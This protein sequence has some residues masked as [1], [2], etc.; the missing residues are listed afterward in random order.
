MKS[1][2]FKPSLL[3]LVILL[4]I[5]TANYAQVTPPEPPEPPEPIHLQE[6]PSFDSKDLQLNMKHLQVKMKDLQKQIKLKMQKVQYQTKLNMKNFDKQFKYR[7]KNM[8]Y[9][10]DSLKNFD[11]QFNDSVNNYV[12]NF[13]NNI[14]PQIALGF[15]D[16]DTNF[17]YNTDIDDQNNEETVE[18]IKNYSKT[19]SVDGNDVINI[20][21][22]FGKIIVNTWAKNEVKVDVQIKVTT[23]SDDK[24]QKL[25]D[26]VNI[27]DSKDGSGISF[28]TSINT[29]GDDDNSWSLFGSK[30]NNVRII[31]I[32]YT[33]YMPSKNPLS[34]SNKYGAV[35]LPD[36]EGKLNINNSYGSLVAKSLSNPANQ[37][38]VKYGSA[39]ID[40]LNG[41]DLDVAYGSLSLGECNKLNADVSYGSARIGRITTSGSINLKFSGGLTISDIDK[42][43]KNLEIN[44]SYSG[45]RLGF[46]GDQNADFDVTV[47]YGEFNYNGHD[48][49]ITSKSPADGERGFSPTKSYKGHFGKGGTN[50][51]ITIN[52]SYGSVSFN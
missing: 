15:K 36:L 30:H 39:T 49:N 20:D 47:R 22:R 29:S 10:M 1:K 13:S 24:A 23:N 34:I 8:V 12:Y 41:S 45:V 28:R 44:S 9:K 52:N 35:S 18:K 38:T 19:Y 33:V 26:N 50:K 42:N 11:Y 37:I 6:M 40:A 3:A 27:R 14:A 2:I 48:I 43:V 46:K 5:S 32:N 31:E 25:L 51:T 7:Y 4:A 17:S 21:N 16:F